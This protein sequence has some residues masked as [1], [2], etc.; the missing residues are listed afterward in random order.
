MRVA[1]NKVVSIDYTLTADDG[2]VLDSSEGS[3]PLAYLHGVGGLIPG[4]ENALE[5]KGV[6]DTFKVTVPPKDGYGEL[7]A[8]LIQKVARKQFAG[9]DDLEV[10]MEFTVSGKG[11]PRMVRIVEIEG[12]DITIDGNHEMAGMTL[13]FDV[14]IRDIREATKEEKEHGHAHSPGGHHHH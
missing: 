2:T 7:D 1:K 10:G 9:I 8:G 5:G 13:H 14:A 12:K 6:G 3:E 11:G 4:L